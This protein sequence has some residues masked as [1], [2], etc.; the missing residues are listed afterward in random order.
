M[1]A[2]IEA[3]TRNLKPVWFLVE[4]RCKNVLK[5]MLAFWNNRN[6]GSTKYRFLQEMPDSKNQIYNI[7]WTDKSASG[8]QDYK[9]AKEFYYKAKRARWERKVEQ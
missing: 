9:E 5:I 1:I 4:I 2:K 3:K 8:H 6:H 7:G